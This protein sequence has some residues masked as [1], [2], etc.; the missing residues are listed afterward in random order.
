[1]TRM[2]RQMRNH[3]EAGD[4]AFVREAEARL[5]RTPAPAKRGPKPKDIQAD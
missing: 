2:A 5:G 1:M 3:A 4:P